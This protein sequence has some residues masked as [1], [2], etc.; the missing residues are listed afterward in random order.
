MT[1]EVREKISDTCKR[2]SIACVVQQ[3][4][5]VPAVHSDPGLMED[6]HAAIVASQEVR[7]AQE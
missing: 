4:T 2:R 1:A 3:K 6:L 7:L 5:A